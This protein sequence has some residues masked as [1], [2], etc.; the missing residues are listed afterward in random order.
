MARP[1]NASAMAVNA[2]AVSPRAG[3]S[4]R[5]D[6]AWPPGPPELSNCARNRKAGSSR[7]ILPK[8]AT[9]CLQF[10][11]VNLGSHDGMQVGML[12]RLPTLNVTI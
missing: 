8:S 4:H 9:M 1:V 6:R 2:P 3:K 11:R 12:P 5:G 10:G 7:N